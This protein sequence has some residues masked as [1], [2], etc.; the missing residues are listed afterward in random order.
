MTFP[1]TARYNPEWLR[2]SASGGANPL[3]LAEWLSQAIHFQPGMRVLDLG[4]GRAA[5]SI[6]LSNEFGCETWACDLWF[7][8]D[9]NAQRI[10][11]AGLE[12]RVI[13]LR[14]DAR[15]LPFAAGF[16]D[17]IIAIDSFVYYGTDDHYL[18]SLARFVKP[19]GVLAIVGSGLVQEFDG[20]VPSHLASWWTPELW[21]LHSA[22][23]W[24]R[25]WER[26]G[27]VDIVTADTLPDGWKLWRDWH[28][29]IAPDNR[30]EIEALEADQ[31]RY[32][33]YV[34]LVA[35]R[36]AGAQLEAP[37]ESVPTEYTRHPLLEEQ[38]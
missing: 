13:P 37:I 14:A 26:T 10:R 7:S 20:P 29:T 9:E 34:R 25:H 22:A 17:A 4:C 21:S 3:W 24:R 28:Q 2:A 38:R 6:F 12:Q 32:L 33:G 5:S 16:F 1:R 36:A 30:P 31:G 8:A 11:D 18:A 27:F 35:R 19:G 15:K 23:W